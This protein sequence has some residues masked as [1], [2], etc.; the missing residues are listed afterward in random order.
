V[1]H[2]Y[3]P[4]D[5]PAAVGRFLDHWRPDLALF[6][7]SELWPTTL[8]ALGRRG[9]PLAVVNARMSERSFRRWNAAAPLA[10]SILGR[11]DLWLAQSLDDAQRLRRLG[12]E[13]L[14]VCG[15]LKFD[16]PP[17]PAD[18]AEVARLRAVVDGKHVLVAASTH[19]GEEAAIIAAHATVS[20]AGSDLLTILAPRHPE[21]GEALEKE[22]TA[23]GLPCARRSRGAR[24]TPESSIY[25][26][27]T[28][29]EMGLWYRLADAAFLGG[30]MVAKGGQNPIE[31]AKLRTPILH[32][33]HVGNFRDVYAALAA[34]NAV[35]TVR[36]GPEFA[37]VVR[38]LMADRGERDRLAREAY[39]C[40]ERFTGALDRTLD[41]LDRYLEPLERT[42]GH[43]SRA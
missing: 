37:V 41:A 22:I 31:P 34:A 40:V 27:D 33:E 10:R 17:P 15:N 14:T 5:V 4:I 24:L 43:A 13:R 36:D 28:I 8:A 38:A 3:Q 26:A 2:Q 21:R 20:G 23:A 29:G 6:V 7:E 16:A 30:S 18:E 25:L 12:A 35:R 39:A 42:G 11:V 1:I 19:P 9:I 32:G